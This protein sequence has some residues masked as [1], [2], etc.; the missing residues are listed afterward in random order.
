[1]RRLRKYAD[2][3]MRWLLEYAAVAMQLIV[4]FFTERSLFFNERFTDS[5]QI[6]MRTKSP[7]DNRHVHVFVPCCCGSTA[8]STTA[9]WNENMHMS[10]G[11]PQ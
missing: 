2:T 9:T 6:L 10:R 8:N 3:A 11:K 7:V 1:M 4:L 5:I